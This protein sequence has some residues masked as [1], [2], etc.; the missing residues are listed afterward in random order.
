VF[1]HSRVLG[2]SRGEAGSVQERQRRS[3]PTSC[4]G[5][6]NAPERGSV[7]P[8]RRRIIHSIGGLQ[9]SVKRKGKRRPRKAR[10]TKAGGRRPSIEYAIKPPVAGAAAAS[11]QTSG[12]GTDESGNCTAT[13]RTSCPV[14]LLQATMR[15][16]CAL[17]PPG[18][19]RRPRGG[20]RRG[21]G[22]VNRQQRREEASEQSLPRAIERERQ[23]ARVGG[24]PATLPA[25]CGR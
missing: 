7:C 21:G 17:L 6:S 20:R 15:W 16:R 13:A 10:R 23:I 12:D 9:T 18:V 19:G 5:G 2:P 25:T 14:R 11:S 24:K 1:S 8:A 4:R 3:E 22:G